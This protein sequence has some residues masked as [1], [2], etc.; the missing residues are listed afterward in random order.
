VRFTHRG[1][2]ADRR[3]RRQAAAWTCAPGT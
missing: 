2:L 3:L 1:H